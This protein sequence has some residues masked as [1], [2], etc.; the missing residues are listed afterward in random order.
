LTRVR[1]EETTPRASQRYH[2]YSFSQSTLAELRH[3]LAQSFGD[4]LNCRSLGWVIKSPL[5]PVARPSTL[6]AP[7]EN[8]ALLH[9]ALT[10]GTGLIVMLH[11]ILWLRLLW[12]T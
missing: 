11:S 7:V 2:A 4:A 1:F 10:L 8:E 5:D 6:N 3:K 9:L 12:F